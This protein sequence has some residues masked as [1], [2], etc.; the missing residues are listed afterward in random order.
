MASSK[1]IKCCGR[2]DI[3]HGV[4]IDINIDSLLGFE[5]NYQRWPKCVW[6][7]LLMKLTADQYFFYD[8]N[9]KNYEPAV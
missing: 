6:E 9:T 2:V 7:C 4:I 5:K 3:V 1:F 8:F